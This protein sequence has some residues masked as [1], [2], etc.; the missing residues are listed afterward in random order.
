MFY[1]NIGYDPRY[2]CHVG[3][4]SSDVPS[5]SLGLKNI[6]LKYEL[7][8][9]NITEKIMNI[10]NCSDATITEFGDLQRVL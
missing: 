7:L 3:D 10:I 1:R 5:K 9:E 4:S 8:P 6:Y 2:I